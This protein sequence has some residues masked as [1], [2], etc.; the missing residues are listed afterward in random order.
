MVVIVL[1]TGASFPVQASLWLVP[2]VALVGLP[3]RDHLWWAGAEA[4]HFGAV[5]LYLASDSVADR[6]LPAGWY[7]LTLFT[8][9]VA[10]CWL[11]Y[12][13]W[14]RAARRPPVFTDD[15]VDVSDDDVD[16]PD[17]D[18]PYTE[19]DGEVDPLAGPLADAADS[20]VVRFR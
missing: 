15:D 5:W 11:G 18:G 13:A 1:V 16:G 12:A 20:L 17:V 19:A 8:R 10:V 14:R 2:L 7:A 9:L 4:L 3:W 6:G